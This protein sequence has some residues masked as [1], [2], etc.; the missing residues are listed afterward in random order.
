MG[1]NLRKWNNKMW[2]MI[3]F[4]F[5]GLCIVVPLLLVD[6]IGNMAKDLFHKYSS[7]ATRQG[8]KWIFPTL[9]AC[10]DIILEKDNDVRKDNSG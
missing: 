10:K 8:D 7:W 6:L 3:L 5:I 9:E 1:R 2:A 4:A